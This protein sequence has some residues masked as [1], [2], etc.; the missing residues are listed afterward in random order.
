LAKQKEV[1]GWGLKNI[2]LVGQ[3]LAIKSLWTMFD[4][5]GQWGRVTKEK[6]TEPNIVVGWIRREINSYKGASMIKKFYG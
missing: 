3:A 1:G 5:E 2:H 4:L 6:Y